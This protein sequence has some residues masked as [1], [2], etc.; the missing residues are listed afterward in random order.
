MENVSLTQLSPSKNRVLGPHLQ[1]S[2]SRTTDLQRDIDSP[3]VVYTHISQE[4]FLG[5]LGIV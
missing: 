5:D 3:R 2:S 4:L 1:C